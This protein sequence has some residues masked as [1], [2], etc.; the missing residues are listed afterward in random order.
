MKI[1]SIQVSHLHRVGPTSQTHT[2][3]ISPLQPPQ[4]LYYQY[5]FLV[6]QWYQDSQPSGT[7][8]WFPE[9]D[10]AAVPRTERTESSNGHLRRGASQTP[11]CR[12]SSSVAS[13]PRLSFSHTTNTIL[14]QYLVLHYYGPTRVAASMFHS[15]GHPLETIHSRRFYKYCS[16]YCTFAA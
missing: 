7:F 1:L 5:R 13:P 11:N 15:R 14:Q 3:Q 8:L 16:R 10:S 2:I 4:P 12:G 6:V 9:L